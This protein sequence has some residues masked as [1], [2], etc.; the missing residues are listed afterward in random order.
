MFDVDATDD[1]S[2][3]GS[4]CEFAGT[5]GAGLRKIGN[6]CSFLALLNDGPFAFD[7]ASKLVRNL[8]MISLSGGCDMLML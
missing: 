1:E 2:M 4:T 3:L 7:G 8:A 5:T 6:I